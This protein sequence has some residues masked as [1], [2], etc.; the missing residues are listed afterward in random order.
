MTFRE[1]TDH[2]NDLR[3]KLSVFLDAQDQEEDEYHNQDGMNYDDL[4]FLAVSGKPENKKEQ[5]YCDLA[6]MCVR[7]GINV[8]EPHELLK[9]HNSGGTLLRLS[10]DQIDVL[11]YI[12][13]TLDNTDY[14]EGE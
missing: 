2:V 8:C 13:L 12:I 7:A 4:P 10:P 14:E 6:V 9:L 1:L 3:T 5:A 11:Q